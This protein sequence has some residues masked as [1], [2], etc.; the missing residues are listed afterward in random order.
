MN[1]TP[2]DSVL[3]V[4]EHDLL[5]PLR[6]SGHAWSIGFI[7]AWIGRIR[8]EVGD[9]AGARGALEESLAVRRAVGDRGGEEESE[10]WLAQHSLIK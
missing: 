3:R 6:E 7:L 5:P 10:R 2:A 8:G 9:L 4:L 1:G